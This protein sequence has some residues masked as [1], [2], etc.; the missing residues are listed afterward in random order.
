MGVSTTLAKREYFYL[1]CDVPPAI[2]LS[3]MTWIIDGDI[4]IHCS[5]SI[6]LVGVRAHVV[7][8]DEYYH[9]ELSSLFFLDPF[10]PTSGP[11]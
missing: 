9:A 8:E 2:G 4:G 1:E 5:T 7:V 6:I 3:R 11:W 10:P